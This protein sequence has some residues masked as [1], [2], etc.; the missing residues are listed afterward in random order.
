MIFH[1]GNKK[2]HPFPD[3]NQIKKL[4]KETNLTYNQVVNWTTNVRKRNMK[5]TVEGGKKPHHFLDFLF[6]SQERDRQAAQ[7]Q[8]EGTLINFTAQNDNTRGLRRPRKAKSKRQVPK[9]REKKN[10]AKGNFLSSSKASSNFY[11]PSTQT[12]AENDNDP[13]SFQMSSF[14]CFTQ[15]SDPTKTPIFSNG[16]FASN[17]SAFSAYKAPVSSSSSNNPVVTPIYTPQ[18][19]S[20]NASNHNE[21]IFMPIKKVPYMPP[22]SPIVS[23]Q[24]QM[25]LPPNLPSWDDVIRSV[26]SPDITNK[27]KKRGRA[28]SFDDGV[29]SGEFMTCHD[30]D[31]NYTPPDLFLKELDIED[32]MNESPSFESKKKDALGL[33]WDLTSFTLDDEALMPMQMSDNIEKVDPATAISMKNKCN[34]LLNDLKSEMVTTTV[35]LDENATPS[36][37][38][39]VTFD[40]ITPKQDASKRNSLDSF[41]SET[42]LKDFSDDDLIF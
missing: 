41:L 15:R 3:S 14:N 40:E 28:H 7:L 38:N 18:S 12:F 8:E 31:S 11:M 16:S 9:K 1:I 4:A 36:I 37:A 20:T 42:F 34:D 29:D 24:P 39:N 6:L 25:K 19:F 23:R 10:K 32:G 33:F 5:A 2:E 17:N 30:E 13:N 35:K 27:G 22:L 21:S 26:K